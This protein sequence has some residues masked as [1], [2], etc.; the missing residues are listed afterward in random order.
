MLSALKIYRPNSGMEEG[1]KNEHMSRVQNS[2][3]RLDSPQGIEWS[4]YGLGC[5][6]EG[7]EGDGALGGEGD[8]HPILPWSVL[9]RADCPIRLGKRTASAGCKVFKPH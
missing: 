6:H 3:E 5:L 7:D 1:D 9:P 8:V 4:P 2:P